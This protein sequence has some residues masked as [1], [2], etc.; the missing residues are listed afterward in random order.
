MSLSPTESIHPPIG[1]TSNA[2]VRPETTPPAP[3]RLQSLDV[4]RGLIMV[5][6]AFNGFGLAAT[7]RNHLKTSPD[8]GFWSAVAHQFQHA[9]DWHRRVPAGYGG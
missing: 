4:Y 8:S 9:T 2:G 7:A 5:T 3:G 6:L 1:T